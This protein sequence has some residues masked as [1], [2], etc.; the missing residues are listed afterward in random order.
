MS[1]NGFFRYTGKLESMQC[2]VED[3]VYDDI[4]TRPRDLIFCGLNNLFGEIMWFYPTSSSEAV[5]RMVS[6]NYL[7][8]TLQR[9]IW[10]SNANTDFARTTWAD[11]SVFGRPYGTAYAP[12]T[13]VASS[14][15]TYVVGNNEGCTTFYQH[16]K[17][18]DQVLST[19]ATTNVLASISSG[20]FD[21]TQDKERGITFKGDG[22]YLMSI[23]RFIPDFLAQTGNV[24]VTLN[25]KNY[26]T[27]SYTSSSLGPFTI[28]TSTTYKSC[29]ARA[30]A[31]Q[32]KIDNTGQSQTWKL[33]TFRL[34]TQADGRR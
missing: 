23:R 30:R 24:R 26:P 18:T 11:S 16:E 6:Y 15:D 1:E 28:T 12:D 10:V 25:L 7:D 29:R 22:E 13:D 14:M 34:D 27:D 33:G 17:G 8:S 31:V 2:L 5:N 9:P 19:G 21:I 4:N 20:D 32:L 3:Y